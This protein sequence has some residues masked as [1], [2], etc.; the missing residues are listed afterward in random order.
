MIL[1]PDNRD[2]YSEWRRLV[3]EHAVRGAKVH[4]ARLVAAMAVHGVTEVLTLNTSDFA[5]Y[6][7]I[8]AVHPQS[9]AGAEQN[10]MT[11]HEKLA[12]MEFLW[13]DLACS[14]EAIE[15]PSWPEKSSTRGA[16]GSP[17]APQV[18]GLGEGEGRDTY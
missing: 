2:V 12:A 1:L 5:R 11:L 17:T 6:P 18:Y 15:S 13:E 9:L 8:T 3:T 16:T 10:E 7:G 4:D 14:P